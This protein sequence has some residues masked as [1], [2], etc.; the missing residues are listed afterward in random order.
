MFTLHPART[1]N[2]PT[3]P[4]LSHG[5]G[6]TQMSHK[7]DAITWPPWQQAAVA[8][9]AA[10]AEVRGTVGRRHKLFT[11]PPQ[12]QLKRKFAAPSADGTNWSPSR[13]LS[14]G[15]S[16]VWEPLSLATREV[17]TLSGNTFTLCGHGRPCGGGH[18]HLYTDK[19]PQHE[20]VPLQCGFGLDPTSNMMHP[21]AHTPILG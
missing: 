19:E 17:A 12:P 21:N 14:H 7:S 4:R 18:I 11:E 3:S 16:R 20:R 15:P 10:E 1:H 9:V 5:R 2:S 8:A 13:P 6:C